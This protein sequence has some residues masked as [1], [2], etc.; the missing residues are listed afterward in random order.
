MPLYEY[1]CSCGNSFEIQL[2]VEERDKHEGKKCP[3]CGS[4]F[5]RSIGNKGGFRLGEKG[6]VG[7]HKDGYGSTIGD[8]MNS[9]AG[10][11]VY[12]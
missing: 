1:G 7:W 9:R 4:S 10:H 11:K 6:A 8:I 5:H 3:E 2:T 12:E